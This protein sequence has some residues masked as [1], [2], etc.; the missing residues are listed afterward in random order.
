MTTKEVEESLYFHYCKK[1]KLIALNLSYLQNVF[2]HEIDFMV[3]SN[4]NYMTEIE[5]KVSKSD[6]KADFKKS[7]NHPVRTDTYY[8]DENDNKIFTDDIT[9][10]QQ[11]FAIP[12]FL[13]DCIDLIPEHF[14][15][16]VVKENGKVEEF[17]KPKTNKARN[18][19]DREVLHLATLQ[20]K[21]YWYQRVGTH[22]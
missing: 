17:R 11:Y 13:D 2:N 14:G 15:I 3:I 19:T 10:K 16:L 18:L 5:I 6:L 22:L 21:K 4:S 7:H 8:R 1:A 9:I 20:A 12:H